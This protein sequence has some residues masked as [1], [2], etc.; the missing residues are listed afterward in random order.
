M[1]KN[2]KLK[3]DERQKMILFPVNEAKTRFFIISDNGT[4][5][6][7]NVQSDADGKTIVGSETAMREV[8]TD[9]NWEVVNRDKAVNP[10]DS[11]A[12]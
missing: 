11:V 7:R 9:N 3:S 10:I 5:V 2:N 12:Y 4:C 1:N 6:G 8:C